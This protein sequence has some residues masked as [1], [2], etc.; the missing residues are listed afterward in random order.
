MQ[1]QCYSID[2]DSSTHSLN[3]CANSPHV[4]FLLPLVLGL[5]LLVDFPLP[6]LSTAAHGQCRPQ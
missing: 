1:I 5:M 4:S 6:L 2:I 3:R